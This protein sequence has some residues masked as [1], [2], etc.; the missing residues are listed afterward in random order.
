MAES[1]K[2]RGKTDISRLVSSFPNVD[3]QKNAKSG[4]TLVNQQLEDLARFPEENPSPV[5]RADRNGSILFANAA[6][7]ML[8]LEC[9]PG[10]FLPDLYRQTAVDV[11][12]NG[13]KKEI[14][15]EANERTFRLDFVPITSAGY[16]NVYGLEIT[17]R[18]KAEAFLR[19]TRDYL[20]NL[21]SYANAPVIVWDP[22]LRITRFNYAFERLT[23]LSADKVLRSSCVPIL[24]IRAP[25]CVVGI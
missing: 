15:V 16:V 19:Q 9:Q 17:D 4:I 21:F 12:K 2:K 23:G 5:M 22:E 11:L 1:I 6:C 25:G 20:D 8:N 14:E 13:L 18:K 24:M 7:S 3:G 10:K